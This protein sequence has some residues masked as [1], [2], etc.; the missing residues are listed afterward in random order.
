MQFCFERSPYQKDIFYCYIDSFYAGGAEDIKNDAIQ[1]DLAR[2]IRESLD[3]N[4]KELMNEVLGRTRIEMSDE[5]IIS[6]IKRK[7]KN[8]LEIEVNE[9]WDVELKY[10]V[11][12]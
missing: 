5:E 1:K 7:I 9:D 2:T 12:K 3:L 4:L 11:R 10:R 8:Q 6:F